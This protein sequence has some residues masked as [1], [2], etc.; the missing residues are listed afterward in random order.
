[1]EIVKRYL[2][3]SDRTLLAIKNVFF[4]FFLKGIAILTSF[5]VV[6]LTINYLNAHDYGIWLTISSILTWINFFDIGL[7]NGLRNKLA[8]ALAVKDIKL[9]KTYVSTTFALLVIIMLVFFLI[10]IVINHFLHW[11]KILNVSQSQRPVLGNMVV[12]VFAFF[13][14][15]FVFKTVGIIFI[16]SQKP[17]YN[18]FLVVLGSLL[19]LAIIYVMTKNLPGSLTNVAYAFAGTPVLVFIIAYFAMFLGKYTYLRPSFSSINFQY[20]NS[21]IGLGL[22]FFVIQ[23]AVCIVIYT[24]TNILLTQLFGSESVTVYNVAFKYFN[25]LSMIYIIILVPFWSAATDAYAKN[26]LLW[27]RKSIRKLVYIFLLTVIASILMI[28]FSEQFYDLWVG[29]SVKIP[30]SLSVL[31]AIYVILFN[32]SNTFIYF[33]NGI[34]KIQLQLYVTVIVAILYLPMAIAMGNMWGINGVVSA[35]IISLI[36]T[37]VIMPIQCKKIFTNKAY[38]FWIK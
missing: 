21:L 16:S 4:S 37:S 34:G 13:C 23:I 15:Q 11:D 6:P 1:M 36:P 10:F 24:S 38:G 19:S 20:T 5:L 14:L 9:A 30:L 35:T 7:T 29:N 22:K 27:I 12:I 26:D 8:E 18:D 17:A 3:N 33:I 31:V 32:W 28:L 2:G 25:A